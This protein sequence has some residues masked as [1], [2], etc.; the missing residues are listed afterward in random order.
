MP[1]FESVFSKL[2]FVFLK[3]IKDIRQILQHLSGDFQLPVLQI[4]R[5]KLQRDP[6]EQYLGTMSLADCLKHLQT[7]G[8][9]ALYKVALRHNQ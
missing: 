1:S 3:R 2:F 4:G 7:F 9:L 6:F 5:P 8:I